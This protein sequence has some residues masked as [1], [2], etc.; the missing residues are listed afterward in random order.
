MYKIHLKNKEVYCS[1]DIKWS[2]IKKVPIEKVE[3]FLTEKEKLV[4]TGFEQYIVL[5]EME[6]IIG[7][8]KP[9]MIS[10]SILA[11][12][13]KKC[14]QATHNLIHNKI[15][16]S[17]NPWGAEYVP[18]VYNWKKQTWVAGNGRKINPDLWLK[19]IKNK[20]SVKFFD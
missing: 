15:T 12:Y 17:I 19:G 18:V 6:A 14:Y 11:K 13:G 3:L 8:S 9:N 4:F 7:I 16:Q 20:P 10:V 5:K 2:E 1:E